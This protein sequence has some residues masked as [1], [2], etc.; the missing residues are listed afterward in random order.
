MFSPA[1]R[2]FSRRGFKAQFLPKIDKDLP[3]DK[4]ALSVDH[5]KGCSKHTTN[6]EVMDDILLWTKYHPECVQSSCVAK[7]IANYLLLNHLCNHCVGGES[8]GADDWREKVFPKNFHL[9]KME[10]LA[11]FTQFKNAGLLDYGLK[12]RE[13]KR[14]WT[15]QDHAIVPWKCQKEAGTR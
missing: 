1:P 8:F 15:V 4:C 5:F 2:K 9:S 11:A 14:F 12:G 6:R 13:R 10:E 7:S 3:F